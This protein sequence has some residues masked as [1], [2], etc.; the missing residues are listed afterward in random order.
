MC[1]L[2][3]YGSVTDLCLLILY[4]QPFCT[5]LWFL[6]FFSWANILTEGRILHPSAQN[7]WGS[8]NTTPICLFRLNLCSHWHCFPG[9]VCFRVVTEDL[10]DPHLMALKCGFQILTLE[11]VEVAKTFVLLA[12]CCC[13]C[14]YTLAFENKVSLLLCHD[15]KKEPKEILIFPERT[16]N[17]KA[18]KSILQDLIVHYFQ[19]FIVSHQHPSDL[20]FNFS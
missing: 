14:L 18:I 9:M 5:H 20:Y 3:T 19:T 8:L 7:V 12:W 2:S 6:G 11:S 16:T 4:L 10:L 1:S 13:W 15:K 17:F